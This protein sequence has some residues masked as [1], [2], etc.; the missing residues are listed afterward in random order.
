MNKLER[1]ADTLLLLEFK[2]MYNSS[3]IG[4][5]SYDI[6][7]WKSDHTVVEFEYVVREELTKD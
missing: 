4:N 2:F 1:G 5:I 6:T 7:F 3:E